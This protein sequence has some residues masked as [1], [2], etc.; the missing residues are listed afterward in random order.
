MLNRK[1]SLGSEGESAEASTLLAQHA[2]QKKYRCLQCPSSFKRPENL[3]RHERGH[4][5]SKR[6]MCQICDK[7]F[8]RSDILGRHVSIHAPLERRNDNP[9]RRRACRE[10]A[11]ARERCS[12]GDP[13]RRCTIKALCCLYPEDPRFKTI[14][15][16]TYS[17]PIGSDSGYYNT[18]GGEWFGPSSL[19]GNPYGG[20]NT[21][22]QDMEPLQQQV[23]ASLVPYREPPVSST[24]SYDGAQPYQSDYFESQ[25]TSPFSYEALSPGEASSPWSSTNISIDDIQFTPDNHELGG[26]PGGYD[27][28]HSMSLDLNSS[29]NQMDFH[30]PNCSVGFHDHY[31]SPPLD[32][33]HPSTAFHPDNTHGYSAGAHATIVGEPENL[34]G[35]KNPRNYEYL[36]NTRMPDIY[37]EDEETHFQ[38]C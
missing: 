5:E 28:A 20:E 1:I 18:A 11:R 29:S 19:L 25:S 3:K 35:W 9:Q 21:L 32:L 12:R 27:Q 7:S 37:F 23:E 13:C 10:C 4:D 16:R 24:S 36:A 8:A 15:P 38:A 2:S 14:A 17:P 33:N 6:F 31:S 30:Q 26:A 34:G 22:L